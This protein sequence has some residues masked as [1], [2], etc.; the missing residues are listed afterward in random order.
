MLRLSWLMGLLPV[1][2]LST[3]TVGA[4]DLDVGDAVVTVD[5]E[6]EFGFKERTLATLKRGTPLTITARR[7]PWL[8]AELRI[9]GQPQKAWL[10]KYE[11]RRAAID[12]QSR[13]DFPAVTVEAPALAALRSLKVEAEVD[14]DGHVQVLNASDTGIPDAALDWLT[15]FPKLFELQL[16]GCAISDAGVKKLASLK[17]L[18]MLYLDRTDI[19]DAALESVAELPELV[20]LVLERT[21]VTGK[22]VAQLRKLSELR[23]LNLSR[24]VVKDADLEMVGTMRNLEVLTLSHAQITG[25]G[26]KHLQPLPKLRV[27]NISHNPVEEEKLLLLQNAPTLKMLYV[28]GIELRESTVSELKDTLSSCAIYRW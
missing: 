10:H 1:L 23:T 24:C 12:L 25:G 13:K 16:G 5:A 21:R 2:L 22:G 14:A 7:D 19:T 8:Q 28:R 17:T 3:G 15:H 4:V 18:E 20:L 9:D 27:L 11:V 26:L 6:V